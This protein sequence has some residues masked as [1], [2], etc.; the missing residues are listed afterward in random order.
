VEVFE[1]V[2]EVDPLF[3]TVSLSVLSCSFTGASWN[4]WIE[5]F[6]ERL[7]MDVVG[8]VR[9]SEVIFDQQMWYKTKEREC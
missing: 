9:L 6:L 7:N 2:G 5:G 8:S 3:V 4:A 1:D